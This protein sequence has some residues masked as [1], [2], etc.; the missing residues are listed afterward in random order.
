MQNKV[1]LQQT[2]TTWIFHF[3][4]LPLYAHLAIVLLGSSQCWKKCP[5]TRGDQTLLADISG[6]MG[7]YTLVHDTQQLALLCRAPLCWAY[8]TQIY[9]HNYFQATSM[10][11]HCY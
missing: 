9:K 7:Y 8:K 1:K 11:I 5:A 6:R 3:G 10:E 4:D 2:K